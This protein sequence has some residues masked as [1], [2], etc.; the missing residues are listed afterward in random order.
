MPCNWRKLRVILA[1]RVLLAH[2][3]AAQ[4][5]APAAPVPR[6]RPAKVPL[7]LAGH[8]AD[9]GRG[10]LR[11]PADRRRR[12]DR[13]DADTAAALHLVGRPI[14]AD[15]SADDVSLGLKALVSVPDHDRLV[16]RLCRLPREELRAMYEAAAEATECATAL[17]KRGANPVTEALDGADVVEEWMH[18]PPDD[19]IDAATHSQYYYHAHAAEE[20]VAG[21][22]GHFHTFVRPKQIAPQLQP[23][24]I[25]DEDAARDEASWITHLIGMSTDASGRV[26]RLFTTN[27]WVTG[28][29][30]Y[31]AEAVTAL[32]ERFD[33]T[34]DQLSRD[35]NR[36]VSAV[37][38]MFRPQIADL[39]RERDEK[40][41]RFKAAHP[42]SDV[43]EDRT[44]Q[45]VSEIPVDFLSQIRAIE[46]VL[47]LEPA[48]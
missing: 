37:L 18:F 22:H 2:P 15:P 3:D 48:Y 6:P 31:D 23:A 9:V 29:V 27:R 1:A 20:R 36:W 42:D 12:A 10:H 45:V 8:P 30:W 47:A 19:V 16:Q 40:M 44:L 17:A 33:I 46:A 35:L 32:A 34:N 39:A 25:T 41:A 24:A 4:A 43:Y 13:P 11:R 38:R 26:I 21:E 5:V 7:T 14:H 28:E